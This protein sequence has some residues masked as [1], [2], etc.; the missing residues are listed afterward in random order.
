MT[1]RMAAILAALR[2]QNES[3]AKLLVPIQETV[4]ETKE[5]TKETTPEIRVEIRTPEQAMA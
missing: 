4:E 3:R 2:K 5:E 1:P